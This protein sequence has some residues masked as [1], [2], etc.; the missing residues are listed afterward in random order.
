M[1]HMK[2]FAAACLCLLAFKSIADES[3]GTET[4][5]YGN[6]NSPVWTDNNYNGSIYRNFFGGYL[7]THISHTQGAI[8]TAIQASYSAHSVDA[9]KSDYW[10]GAKYHTGG[11]GNGDWYMGPKLSV[12]WDNNGHSDGAAGWYENYVVE[13]SNKNPQQFEDWLESQGGWYLGENWF[14]GIHY[15]FYLRPFSSWNQFWAVRQYDPG[16]EQIWTPVKKILESW[17]YFGLPNKR[18]DSIRLNVETYGN[19]NRWFEIKQISVPSS[20]Y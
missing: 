16:T 5:Y 18:L 6:Y 12:N 7:Y 1:T 8:D 3:W 17:R 19:N 4:M 9:V 14:S 11:S 2:K 20:F 15:K 13:R 10:V